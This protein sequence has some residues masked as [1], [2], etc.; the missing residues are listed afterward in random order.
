[1]SISAIIVNYHTAELLPPLLADLKDCREISEI[2]VVDNSGE[3]ADSKRFSSDIR[4]IINEQN[5]G[6]GAAVNQAAEVA[7][8]EWLLIV[9]PD[10]RLEKSCVQ[11]LLD[12][13]RRCNSPIVGPR[14]YWDEDHR[15]RIPP[16]TGGSLW[17]EFAARSAGN[18]RLD[19][20]LFMFYWIMRHERFWEAQEPFFEPFLSGACL[21]IDKAWA[22]RCDGK[23]FDERFFLYFEDTDLCVRALNDRLRPVCVPGAVAVHYYNQSPNPEKGKFCL[24]EESSSAF[25]NKIYGSVSFP[26]FEDKEFMPEKTDL[27]LITEAHG[28]SRKTMSEDERYYFEVGVNPLLV[29]FIQTQIREDMF[30]FPATI[31]NRIAP[32]QYFCR[33]RGSVSGIQKVWTWKKS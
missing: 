33:I 20:E 21:L 24:M 2:I 22:M 19:A 29:P 27:G 16:A 9:N 17:L 3:L 8:G 13:A 32:G 18:Y 10:I 14:F 4:I 23:V 5:K 11:N 28:F 25:M 12:V 15:F 1:M 31:W 7:I 30:Y 6:F 26:V